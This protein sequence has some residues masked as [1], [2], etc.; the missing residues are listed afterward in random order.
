MLIAQ[1]SDP[2]LRPPGV[3]YQGVVDSN[4]M[5]VSAIRQINALS[6]CPDLVI[7][8]GDVVDE[9]MAVEYEHARMILAELKSPLAVI[10]GNHDDRE[11]FRSCFAD[12][13]YIAE[14]GPLHVVLGNRGHVRIIGLDVTVPG[15][16]HGHMNKAAA[17]WLD[18]VL[19]M[20]PGRPT[21]IMMHQPPLRSGIPYIDE[22]RCM[23]GDRLA[24][25]VSRHGGVKLITCG[26]IHR[27]MM[28]G[29]GGT[30]LCTAPS[31][32]TAIALRLEP[33]ALPASF[34]EPPAFLLHHWTPDGVLVTHLV[35]IGT[36]PGPYSFF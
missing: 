14:G 4:A 19:A 3:L 29:F 10:P 26:H 33:E 15:E 8:S 18:G 36:F 35:P 13:A 31:T 23:D 30:V 22:Y 27:F 1:I 6:P 16:H 17:T 11:T 24:E 34:I 32:T 21:I 2:H 5:L 12:H 25:V 28:S 20:E 7:L 9:G